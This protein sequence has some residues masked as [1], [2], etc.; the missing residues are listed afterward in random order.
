VL[1]P[2]TVEV[3]SG[4][5]TLAL[6]S[7]AIVIATGSRPLVPP[8]A[9]IEEIGYLTSDT[10]WTLRELPRRLL[11]LGGGPIG[12]ELAQCFARLGSQVVL[13]EALPRL[14]AREDPE[15][16]TLL[17][18]SFQDEGITMLTGHKATRFAVEHGA[19]VLYCAH[20]AGEIRVEF[21]QVL[22]AV[23]RIAN[24]EG[25]GLEALAIRTSTTKT[26]EVDDYLQTRVP[27]I[28][29]CGDVTG[30][31]QFTHTAAHTAWYASVNALFGRLWK[32]RADYRVIPWCTFTDPEVA[33]VGL[34]ESEAKD[35]GV[36]HE[37]SVYRIDELD[38][39]ITDEAARGFVKVLTVPG[40]DRI[41]GATIVSEH[42][43]ELVTEF[44]T[45]MK[46]GIG[47]KRMLS[48]IHV[49]PTFSEAN[50]HVSGEW[51]RAHASASA[52]RWVERYHAWMRC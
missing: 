35:R 4:S 36:G 33:R 1:S 9:G 21:D 2:Y 12:C 7:R 34:N 15:V 51:R 24:T 25:L 32:F 48:T 17:T 8:I 14:L 3:R 37:V 39:A 16:A 20:E 49:Y 18:Q 31:Y 52:L 29:A 19:K 6:T 22:C 10:I 45:A 30:P 41:L 44:V 28:Y 5:Q 43:G 27:T 26:I 13:V 38:R 47:L 50:K 23:G 46:H 11:V 40:R 42:A